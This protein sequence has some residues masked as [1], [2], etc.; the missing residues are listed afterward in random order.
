MKTRIRFTVVGMPA[1]GGSK[2]FI[3]HRSTGRMICMDDGKGNAAW[4]RTVARFAAVAYRGP[5]LEGAVWV[6]M[7]FIVPRPKDHYGTGKN[8]GTLKPSAPAYPTTKP[9]VLKLA[10]STEDALTGVIWKD[11][12]ATVNLNLAKRYGD[13][14]G[15]EIEIKTW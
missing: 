13:K 8:A 9:D 6:N 3:P 12:S 5:L 15:V 11:D 14:P 7:L 10:R 4:K 2:K 1:P